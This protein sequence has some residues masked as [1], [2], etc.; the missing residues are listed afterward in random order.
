M[1]NEISCGQ[2]HS[3]FLTNQ[4]EILGLG[5]NRL[6]QLSTPKTVKFTSIMPITMPNVSKFKGI[7]CCSQHSFVLSEN[8]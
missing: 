7:S 2:N 8:N 6:G 3:L 4:G 1:I 5:D